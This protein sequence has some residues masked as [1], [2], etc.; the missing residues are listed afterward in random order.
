MPP[1]QTDGVSDKGIRVVILP[2]DQRSDYQPIHP[3][4]YLPIYLLCFT[5]PTLPY[6]PSALVLPM[7]LV[8]P[9]TKVTRMFRT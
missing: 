1:R 6:L 4:T 5:L 2:T 9:T 7:R 3:P 8:V